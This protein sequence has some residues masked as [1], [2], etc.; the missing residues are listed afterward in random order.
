MVL[1]TRGASKHA[2]RHRQRQ[3]AAGIGMAHEESSHHQK[4][5]L[6]GVPFA[7]SSPAEPTCSPSVTSW[8]A[9]ALGAHRPTSCPSLLSSPLRPSLPP[10]SHRSRQ[11]LRSAL[12]PCRCC[13]S[14]FSEPSQ[15]LN[16]Y[17]SAEPSQAVWRVTA[18]ARD[19]FSKLTGVRQSR[20]SGVSLLQGQRPA[21]SQRQR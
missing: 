5:P 2:V 13:N 15:A 19:A 1:W 16:R 12:L 11:G 18:C 6:L 10:P 3:T 20:D 14:P 4:T 7:R 21:H 17:L 8:A 9:K